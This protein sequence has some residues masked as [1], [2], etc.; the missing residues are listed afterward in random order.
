MLNIDELQEALWHWQL[1]NF[2]NPSQ[3]FPIV[4][5]S[6]SIHYTKLYDVTKDAC[7]DRHL[8]SF[9]PDD[10]DDKFPQPF[11]AFL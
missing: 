8:M 4:I 5:T 1:N 2:G 10:R 9:V 3:T 7:K 6:Y 11:P